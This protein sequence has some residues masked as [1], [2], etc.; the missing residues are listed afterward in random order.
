[1]T[2]DFNIRDSLWDPS[3]PFYS[4]ISD[5]LIM[6]ADSFDLSLSMPT[7][8]GPT[9]F[10]D[11]ARES[12][13]VIDLMF[14]WCGS[15]ELDHHHILPDHR[16]SSDHAPLVIDIPIE[17]KFVQSTKLS[18][19][20]GSDKE[21]EFIKNIISNMSILN[22]L[23][24]NN[25][26][27]LINVV[28]RLGSIVELMWLKNSKRSKITKHSKQWWLQSC[29]SAIN[30]YR[31]T[32]SR[33]DWKSFK[34]MVKETKCSFFD[35]KICE[36]ANSKRG[37]WELMNWVKKRR[38]PATEAIKFNGSPCLSLESLWNALHNTFNNALHRQIDASIL[39]EI[40][41]KPVHQWSPFSVHEFKSAIIKSSDSS[42][43]GPDRMSWRHWKLIF[44]NEDC[45]SKVINIADA[46]INLG[47]WPDYFKTSTTIVIPKPNKSLY[48]NPKAFRP[49]VLL[50]TLGKLIKK[51]IAERIQF[52]VTSNDFIHP[53]QLGGL[54]FKS[55]VDA[56]IALTHIVRSGWVKGKSTSTLAFDI[57]Q[58]FPSLNHCLLILILEKAGLNPKVTNFFANYLVR[59]STKYLWNEFLSPSLMVDVGVG[60]GSALSPILSTLYLSPLIYILEKRLKNLNLPISILSFVDDGLLIAQNK[61]FPT[62]NA[63][64]FCS[65][66]ILLNL[67]NSFGLAVEHSKTEVFHF[68]RSHGSFNPPPLDLSPIGGPI[69]QPKD[70][71]KYLGFI[72]DRKLTFH[73]HIDFYANKAISTV[74][75]MK[76]LG[77]STRGI[78]PL[79]KRLLYRCYALPIVL[80]GFQL[81]FYNKA[82]TSYHMKILNKMQ[83]RAATWILGAFKTSPLEGIE[84]LAGLMPI[85]FHLQKLSKRSLIC[86]SKLPTNHILRNLLIDDP[87]NVNS[88]NSH[89]IGSL[90]KR[91]KSS[92]KGHLNDAHSKL[93]GIF[94]SFSPIDLE[95]SPGNCIV[96]TFSDRYSFNLVNKKADKPNNL[97]SQELDEM[98]LR[99]SSNSQAALIVMD[100]SIKNDIATS[101]SHIHSHNQPLVK[102][103]HHAS[104]V[105]TMEAELFAIRCGI[106]QACSITNVS[107]IVVVTDSIHAARKIF[108]IESHPYQIHTTAILS[109]L[110][111]FFSSNESNSIEFWECPSKLRWRFH[112]LVDKDSKSFSISPSYP[113]KVSWDYCKKIDCEDSLNLW[114]MTFQA[115]DRKGRNF[116][117]LLDDDSNPIEPHFKKGGPWLQAFRCS[118]SLCTRTV[119]AITNHAPIGE[120]RLRFFPGLDFSCPYADYPIETRR[121]ILHECKRFT[122]YW[123]SRRDTLNHFVIFLMANPFAF[124]F[125]DN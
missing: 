87:P 15:F 31:E 35:N 28:N 117:E 110:C 124:V 32:R 105:T 73:K 85:R 72:F 46:C 74:K 42:A 100:A 12:N 109:E 89:N 37:P 41:N 53:S 122:G 34:A 16:L 47:Y 93:L 125:K 86:P 99:L 118:N 76:L 61:S 3:F 79:Q 56:G 80:Y 64:L 55:T 2:G 24:I 51:V 65:Y 90:T 121:H 7:N 4:S 8:P 123:N 94:P 106:N 103:V 49:I 17:D 40:E 18:I 58:F 50:N 92:L 6:I 57:S 1:M 95:F 66:N 88:S 23:N 67:L 96:D 19:I 20:P 14:L 26:D 27:N 5:N 68:S 115:S 30:K 104:F 39:N 102:M 63:Q 11:T 107:K 25:V 43:P 71:W 29:H 81:W 62:S 13:S 45:L 9:R 82:P 75:C 111:N 97:R 119:R 36:I 44:A 77:N 70:S 10:S 101:I 21:K 120:Y 48:D 59:R 116:L 91:Q 113:T 83:R 54:K 98:V 38:L 52:I 84:A 69:L 60:Q 112:S 33:D 114:K 108:A 78:N 22:T